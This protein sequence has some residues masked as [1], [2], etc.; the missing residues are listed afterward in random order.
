MPTTM[1]TMIES[2]TPNLSIFST[3]LNCRYSMKISMNSPLPFSSSITPKLSGNDE[4]STR[5]NG[6]FKIEEKEE[7]FEFGNEGKKGNMKRDSRDNSL[8]K[9][10]RESEA[11]FY[12]SLRNQIPNH[13]ADFLPSFY[14]VE[15]NPNVFIKMSDLSKRFKKTNMMDIKMGTR[16]W[17]SHKTAGSI[18]SRLLKDCR[19]T[20]CSLGMR[21]CG[22]W[23]FE[24]EGYNV[25]SKE[26]GKVLEKDQFVHHIDVYLSANGKN[27][28]TKRISIVNSF[29]KRLEIIQEW[30]ENEPNFRFISSS[31][32][33]L[34]EGND[35]EG[36]NMDWD[37][38]MIDFSNVFEISNQERDLGYLKGLSNLI[39][40][41]KVLKESYERSQS[42]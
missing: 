28:M 40:I 8:W 32:L 34:Y 37:L 36:R 20:T 23:I 25:F 7:E 17:G 3:E 15:R 4:V 1:E 2:P 14:G 6:E 29:L 39:S 18:T 38:R 10:C 5:S 12:L 35:P 16:T 26:D 22:Y 21:H 11:Q 31:I 9:P 19:S 30:M 13:I 33:F 41:L 27:S 42:C 24:K